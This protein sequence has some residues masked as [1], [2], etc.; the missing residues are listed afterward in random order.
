MTTTAELKALQ[1]PVKQRY[2]DDPAA[3]ITALRADGSFADLGI[4]CTVRTFAGPVRA[5]LHRATGG[6]GTDACSGDMLLE[7]IVACAGVTCR[8]VATALGLP[9]TAATRPRSA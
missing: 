1:A 2:R 5:G 8:S 3:A 7:A 6:D 9:I 4:T